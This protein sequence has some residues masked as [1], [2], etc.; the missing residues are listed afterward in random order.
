[1]RG[2]NKKQTSTT[3]SDMPFLLFKVQLFELGNNVR[4]YL[5]TE[6]RCIW[7]AQ[8]KASQHKI[9]I[10]KVDLKELNYVHCV[11]IWPEEGITQ[12]QS[13]CSSH[14]SSTAP[15]TRKLH[16]IDVKDCCKLEWDPW[17]NYKQESYVH[18]SS[19]WSFYI[20]SLTKTGKVTLL[21][22][23]TSPKIHQT[24]ASLSWCCRM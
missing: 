19:A 2:L 14:K 9:T 5:W 13:T 10:N 21:H 18:I 7:L 6:N 3:T 22:R 24:S 8:K 16:I 1:M 12:W 20:S 4:R 11:H 23:A 15:P 17:L